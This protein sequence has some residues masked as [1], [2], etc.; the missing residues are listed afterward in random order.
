MM[1]WVVGQIPQHFLLTTAWYLPISGYVSV[2][3]KVTSPLSLCT[4]GED[5]STVNI[6]LLH[7]PG[8]VVKCL[9]HSFTFKDRRVLG[10]KESRNTFNHSSTAST[11]CCKDKCLWI[12]YVSRTSQPLHWAYWEVQSP[13]A[14]AMTGVSWTVA[15]YLLPVLCCVLCYVQCYVLYYVLCYVV[16]GMSCGMW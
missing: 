2:H 7:P 1:Y 15:R 3:H 5:V 6:P 8:S 16:G 9:K 4:G 13:M 12:F 11:V 10:F 14:Y